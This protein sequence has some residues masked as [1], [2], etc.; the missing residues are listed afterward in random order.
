MSYRDTRWI[1]VRSRR[2]GVRPFAFPRDDKY[3]Q[4]EIEDTN[5]LLNAPQFGRDGVYDLLAAHRS[6]V[7]N[8]LEQ[9]LC[10]LFLD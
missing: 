8:T 4:A 9:R 7:R 5:R 3:G 10:G 2:M 1:R 6:S